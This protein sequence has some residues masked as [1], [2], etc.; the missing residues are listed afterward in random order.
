MHGLNRVRPQWW[1][2]L[3]LAHKRLALPHEN[4]ELVLRPNL[5]IRRSFGAVFM[6]RLGGGAGDHGLPGEPGDLNPRASAHRKSAP[7]LDRNHLRP[8]PLQSIGG[9]GPLHHGL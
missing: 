6:G 3:P 2:C 5:G 7:V 8:G 9:G 4:A 1:N